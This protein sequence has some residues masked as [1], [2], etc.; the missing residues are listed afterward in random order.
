MPLYRTI[1]V[2]LAC[3]ALCSAAFAA[4]PT[5]PAAAKPKSLPAPTVNLD[6]TEWVVFVADVVNPTLNARNVFRSDRPYLPDFADDL[7]SASGIVIEPSGFQP[8]DVDE[9]GSVDVLRLG[10]R[11]AKSEPS[12]IGL[13]RF[14]ADGPIDK[15]AKVDVK[16]AFSGGR[17]LAHWPRAKK[18]FGSTIWEDLSFDGSG[19]ER[20]LPEGSWLEALRGSGLPLSAG[21]TRE[22]FLL[23]DLE[24]PYAVRMKVE[25]GKNEKYSVAQSTS[26]AM[27]DLTFYKRDPEKWRT[28][29]VEALKPTSGV[30]A[31][32]AVSPANPAAQTVQQVVTINGVTR[33]MVQPVVVGKVAS[34]PVATPAK[35]GPPSKPLKPVEFT[36]GAGDRELRKRRSRRGAIN[37]PRPGFRRLTRMWCSKFSPGTRSI[38]S[39]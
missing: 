10:E 22:S 36:L 9:K 16:I 25:G 37:W 23:Y 33:T 18:R 27:H 20:K 13:I 38:R 34:P 26:A 4:E 39:N 14:S 29:T 31:P 15:Q 12:P 3:I 19:Q 11:S 35:S 1:L 24:L 8:T 6:V 2:A 32:A 28:A 17:M 7:R 5:K 21:T 30:P